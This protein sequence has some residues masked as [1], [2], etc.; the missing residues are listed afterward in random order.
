MARYPPEGGGTTRNEVLAE[1][2]PRYS[3]PIVTADLGMPDAIHNPVLVA[4]A[5]VM[6]VGCLAFLCIPSLRN[7]PR[8][9][10][11]FDDNSPLGRGD[12]RAANARTVMLLAVL[13]AAL[14]DNVPIPAPV[15][16]VAV[17]ALAAVALLSLIIVLTQVLFNW[18]RF[19]APRKMRA[20]PGA[21]Q[22]WIH[23]AE[24]RRARRKKV[25][26]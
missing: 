10:L 3:V 11:F 18:P 9:T 26:R 17:V 2:S 22:E 1:R 14:L 12:I 8:M 19:L 16:R 23:A 13:S 25:S 4:A 21:V 15:M 20:Q 5:A 6:W 7:G 24:R